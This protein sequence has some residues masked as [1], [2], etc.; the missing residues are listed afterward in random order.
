M[1]KEFHTSVDDSKV[2]REKGKWW[3]VGDSNPRLPR[4]ERGALPAELTAHFCEA[5]YYNDILLV[6]TSLFIAVPHTTNVVYAFLH[7]IF[8]VDW[9]I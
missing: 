9:A 7:E 3:T 8:Q 2:D 6:P 5:Y 1:R 4:C